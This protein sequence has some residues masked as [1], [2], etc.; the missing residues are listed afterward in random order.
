MT[1][2]IE[3]PRE[4]FDRLTALPLAQ[5]ATKK[6]QARIAKLANLVEN[7]GLRPDAK[8]AEATAEVAKAQPKNRCRSCEARPIGGGSGEENDRDYARTVELCV[9]CAEEAGWENSHGDYSHAALADGS[10]TW[11]GTSYKTK[12]AF[13]E[14]AT[15]ERASMERCWICHPEL[16]RASVDYAGRTGTSRE[17]MVI[18]V[19]VRASGK[20]KAEAVAAKIPFESKVRTVKGVTTLRAAQEKGATLVLVWDERGRWDYSAS[21]VEVDG[22][23]RK[24]RNASEALR[25]CGAAV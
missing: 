23:A 4:E 6:T 21:R 2:K 25:L 17:G 14:W 11:K 19:P 15:D 20:E 10:L 3:T 9:P 24:I 16:N 22:K 12:K 5:Q 1:A 13:D 18:V 8:K 7:T